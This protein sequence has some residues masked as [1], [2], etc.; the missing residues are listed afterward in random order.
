MPEWRSASTVFRVKK[1]NNLNYTSQISQGAHG[2]ANQK[3]TLE[4]REDAEGKEAGLGTLL[5]EGSGRGSRRKA[6]EAIEEPNKRGGDLGDWKRRKGPEISGIESA[7][8]DRAHSLYLLYFLGSADANSHCLFLH[9]RWDGHCLLSGQRGPWLRPP[10]STT[11]ATTLLL[12]GGAAPG[13][14][15]CPHPRPGSW[16]H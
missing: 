16:R 3:G 14:R 13:S 10:S 15:R 6:G 1:D 4:G 8:V 5:V 7:V 11:A 9:S 12:G 2:R